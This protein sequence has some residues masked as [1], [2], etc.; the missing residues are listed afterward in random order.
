MHSY[1]DTEQIYKSHLNCAHNY[2]KHFV[3][4]EK[5]NK[6]YKPYLFFKNLLVELRG[7]KERK[8]NPHFIYSFVVEKLLLDWL[9]KMHFIGKSITIIIIIHE[10]IINWTVQFIDRVLG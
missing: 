9:I 5:N 4:Q 6:V 3:S 8:K 1:S 2:A 10:F 7:K